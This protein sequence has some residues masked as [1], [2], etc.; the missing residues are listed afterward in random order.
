LA[1]AWGGGGRIVKEGSLFFFEKKNQK[2]FS[3]LARNYGGCCRGTGANSQ[4]FF[5]FFKTERLS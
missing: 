4:T 1:V 5:A 3:F 2:T